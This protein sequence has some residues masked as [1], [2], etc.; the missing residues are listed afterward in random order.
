MGPTNPFFTQFIS[1]LQL[2]GTNAAMGGHQAGSH[3][4]QKPIRNSPAVSTLSTNL[5]RVRPP[6]SVTPESPTRHDD[7]GQLLV[8]SQSSTNSRPPL[9]EPSSATTASSVASPTAAD[10]ASLAAA[11]VAPPQ[12]AGHKRPQIS[13]LSLDS[14]SGVKRIKRSQLCLDSKSLFWDVGRNTRV[15]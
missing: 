7:N 4:K 14:E 10:S 1:P 6:L 15:G 13:K 8:L 3:K 11:Q 12:Q 5:P 2:A 9:S